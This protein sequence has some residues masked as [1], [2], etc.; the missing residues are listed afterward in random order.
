[1][2]TIKIKPGTQIESRFLHVLKNHDV[3]MDLV[4]KRDHSITE[5]PYDEYLLSDG[6]M[7]IIQDDL[8]KIRG[9]Y[10]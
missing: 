2:K 6:L 9:L 8:M 3:K 5:K 4:M 10:I 7:R 1:M